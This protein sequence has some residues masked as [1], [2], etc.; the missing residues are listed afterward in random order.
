[1]WIT[2]ITTALAGTTELLASQ[3]PVS[4]ASL[5]PATD[6]LY[7]SLVALARPDLTPSIVPMRAAQCLL[8]VYPERPD[9][10]GVI[11]PWMR[12]PATYGFALLVAGKVDELPLALALEVTDSGR[13]M[14]DPGLRRRLLARLSESKVAE[15]REAAGR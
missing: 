4:C 3:D 13:E 11:L 12:D 14:S 6:A 1:M 5:G 9:L 7:E 15:V 2:L 8:A 10:E